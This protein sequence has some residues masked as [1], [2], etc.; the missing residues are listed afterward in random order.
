MNEN[1][2]VAGDAGAEDEGKIVEK[3]MA[4]RAKEVGRDGAYLEVDAQGL[5]AA[6]RSGEL[7]KAKIVVIKAARMELSSPLEVQRLV[8]AVGAVVEALADVAKEARLDFKEIDGMSDE[9]ASLWLLRKMVSA[10]LCDN[11]YGK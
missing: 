9:Q 5:V 1:D 2:D 3:T 7:Q 6:H 8:G 11:G 4:E 10:W